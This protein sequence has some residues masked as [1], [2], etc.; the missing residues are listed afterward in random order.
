MQLSQL[1]T[2][3]IS[4]NVPPL[5]GNNRRNYETIGNLQTWW[6]EW[7]R[8][9]SEKAKSKAETYFKDWTR[10][11]KDKYVPT[12]PKAQL[13]ADEKIMVTRIT[14]LETEIENRGDWVNKW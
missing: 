1:D 8:D 7:M 4:A 5:S 11:L 6:N 14:N 9:R 13:T 10:K 2:S 12:D 3:W